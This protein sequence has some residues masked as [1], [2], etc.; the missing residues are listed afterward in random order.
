MSVSYDPRAVDRRR[1]LAEIEAELKTIEKKLNWQ[2]PCERTEF[3]F[4]LA[5]VDCS[6]VS[7]NAHYGTRFEVFAKM[8]AVVFGELAGS[9]V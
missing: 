2:Q 9:S 8:S 7:P 1:R 3:P 4:G 5:P 6:P